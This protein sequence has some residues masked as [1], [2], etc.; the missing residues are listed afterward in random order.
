MNNINKY[1]ACK[2]AEIKM[3]D[4]VGIM[5]FFSNNTCHSHL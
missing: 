2:G 5:L 1:S 4:L 3:K